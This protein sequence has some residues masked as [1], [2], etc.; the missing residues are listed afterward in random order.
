MKQK[1]KQMSAS[2]PWQ[3]T[4]LGILYFIK[5]LFIAIMLPEM[6][7]N[8]FGFGVLILQI[9]I[10]RGLFKGEKWSTVIST[11]FAILGLAKLMTNFNAIYF[12]FIVFFIYLS[13]TCLSHPFYKKN[14]L[15]I[16]SP[17]K[18]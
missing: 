10:S 7:S 12:I 17:N 3:G 4:V 8:G 16:T 15:Q 11:I 5:A 9:F 2:R 18:K 1:L 13:I 6:T 14:Q